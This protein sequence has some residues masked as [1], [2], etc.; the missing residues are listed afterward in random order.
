MEPQEAKKYNKLN[1]EYKN[2]KGS[3]EGATRGRKNT[4]KEGSHRNKGVFRKKT[5]D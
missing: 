5:N 1:K 3:P 4:R 2:C